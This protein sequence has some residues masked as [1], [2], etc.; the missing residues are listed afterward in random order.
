[1]GLQII[2]RQINRLFIVDDDKNSRL[3]L[4]ESIID[5][6][7]EPLTIDNQVH[8]INTFLDLFSQSDAVLSDHQ[9]KK[10]KFF[11]VNGAELISICYQKF[12]PGILSTRYDKTQMAEIRKYRQF[13]PV[14][15]NPSDLETDDLQ[16]SL[17]IC[18][19]EFKGYFRRDRTLI[20]TM[21][22]IDSV[23]PTHIYIIIPGWDASE[24]IMVDRNEL[25]D[26]VKGL[27]DYDKRLHV[28]ANIGCESI[29]DLYFSEW[30]IK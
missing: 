11:P 5:S 29:Y 20:R 23:D 25:P 9:M 21:V 28:K 4:K 22:R 10:T 26:N 18:V 15:I 19:Q 1:M 2:D 30:E 13:I 3:M 27:V 8:D 6:E 24:I 17:E 7:L 16:N 12:I 14:L